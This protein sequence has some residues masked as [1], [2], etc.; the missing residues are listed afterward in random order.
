MRQKV[1]CRSE[2]KNETHNVIIFIPFYQ[3]GRRRLNNLTAKVSDGYKPLSSPSP[4]YLLPPGPPAGYYKTFCPQLFAC[5]ICI[6]IV[7]YI[8]DMYMYINLMGIV[9][10]SK[11]RRGDDDKT[12]RYSRF[13]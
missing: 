9:V 10:Y 3:T 6:L 1:F 5:N 4:D 11:P 2:I 13:R 7:K 12:R 8:Y